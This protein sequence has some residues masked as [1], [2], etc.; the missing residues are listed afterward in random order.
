MRPLLIA[1]CTSCALIPVLLVRPAQM[2]ARSSAAAPYTTWDSYLGGGHSAQFTAL[3]QINTANVAKLEVAWRFPAGKRTFLF[4]PLV[5]DGLAFVL[6]GA[7]DLVALDAATGATVWTRPHPGAVGTRG[8]NYWRSADGRDRRLLYIADGNLTAVDAKTGQTVSTFGRD[9]RVDLRTGLATTG[10]SI[11]GLSPLQTSNPGR[12]FENLIIVSLPALRPGYDSNPGDVQAYD[13]RTGALRWVFRSLPGDGEAG[14]DTW[15]KGARV[16]RGG[17]HNWSEL[18]IDEAR[19]IAYVPFGTG[20]FDFY[21]GD[22]PGQNLF[23]NSLVAL[24]A[25]TGKRLWHYQTV[26][27]DVWDYDLPV[28]PKLLTIRHNGRRRDVVA[29]ATKQG[30]LFVFD[31]VTGEPI[32]PIEERAVPQSDV[33]GERTWPT[34]PF[35]TRPA[36]FARQSFT[37][38]DINPYL[39]DDERRAIRERLRSYRND[40]LFTPPSFR[41]SIEMPGHSG[42]TNWGAVAADPDS[43]EVF[44]LSKALPTMIRLVMPGVSEPG[45]SRTG[46][47][48]DRRRRRG[49]AA[50]EGSKRRAAE[51]SRAL[52]VAV[53]LHVH[54]HVSV[55]DRSTVVGNRRLRSQLRRHQVAGAARHRRRARGNRDPAG[56]R[57]ALASRGV[58]GDGRR[59]VVCRVRIG[60]DPSCV[61][62]AH[63]TGRLDLCVAR[64]VGRRAGVVR[65][66]RTSIHPGAGRSRERLESGTLSDSSAGAGRIPYMAFALPK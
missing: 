30:F 47:P 43:G 57:R 39:P 7:N 42:G 9:G 48:D 23:A 44:V 25:R 54:E 40:G 49:R 2:S 4:N 29:Q 65:K 51:G 38:N 62:P 56:E 10:R 28:A 50:H 33:P 13:V 5:A 35:P 66:W 31:R 8:I 27:H 6:A 41:G 59:S 24:D 19:G 26:H 11:D 36:P 21:G 20:R 64:G 61:R 1:V 15:P 46:A 22:R 12:V 14:A 3:R 58:A 17:V 32:W 53:R 45:T 37:E 18:T 63:G 60:Q 55:A 34:Q 52:H 16:D